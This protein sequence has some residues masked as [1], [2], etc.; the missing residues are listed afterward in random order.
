MVNKDEYKGLSL[1]LVSKVQALAL[2]VAALVLSLAL[3]RSLRTLAL[4]SV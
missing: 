3:T 4:I 1:A 2:R